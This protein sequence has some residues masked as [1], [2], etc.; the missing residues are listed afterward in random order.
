MPAFRFTQRTTKNP[1]GKL[2]KL[3]DTATRRVKVSKTD[4]PGGVGVG[5]HILL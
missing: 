3:F 1:D 2:V 5:V 4:W